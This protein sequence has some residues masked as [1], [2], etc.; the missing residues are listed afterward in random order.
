MRAIVRDVDIETLR[1][2]M[3][4]GGSELGQILPEVRT[5]LGESTP[6][7]TFDPDTPRFVLFD[8]VASFLRAVASASPLVV[9]LDDVH[10]ADTPS[11]LLLE[12]LARELRDAR[13]ALVVSYR[14][15]EVTPD[16]A[17]AATLAE[18]SRV[19]NACRL[20]LAGFAPGE[21]SEYIARVTGGE[22]ES[23]IVD[24]LEAR[25]DGNPLFV[26]EIVRI[27]VGDA[28]S[29]RA[30]VRLP[31]EIPA[32]VQEA[33]TWRVA[34]LSTVCRS[35]LDTAAILGR[36]V[37]LD[38]L[39]ALTEDDADVV[40][41]A[42]DEA[43]TAGILTRGSAATGDLRFSHVLVRDALYDRLPTATRGRAHL[44]A[45]DVI[46]T[47][48]AFGP[49]APSQRDRAPPHRGRTGSRPGGRCQLRR[50]CRPGCAGF[51]RA[52]GSHPLVRRRTRTHRARGCG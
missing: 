8:A 46:E 12:F 21:I 3:D 19:P 13:I 29:L 37:P 36:D 32:G 33:I 28:R 34:T 50:G 7:A 24:A 15:T 49:R 16:H 5:S 2:W 43:V 42:L 48:R 52:R 45:A 51:A 40:L 17:V 22:A 1:P 35:T 23:A 18:L 10:G 20:T 9:A 14:S 47:L 41:D 38:I 26:G 31:D 11:L 25:T 44:R 4:S 30:R 39:I 27:M 6:S